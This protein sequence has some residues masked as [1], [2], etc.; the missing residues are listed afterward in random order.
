MHTHRA[1]RTQ[2]AEDSNL[3]KQRKNGNRAQAELARRYG[4]GKGRFVQGMLARWTR[5][6]IAMNIY[7]HAQGFVDVDFVDVDAAGNL[8]A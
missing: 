1:D 6:G 5:A 8:R 3:C 7:A 2:E 4:Q